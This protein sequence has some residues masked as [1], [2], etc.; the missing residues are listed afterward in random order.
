MPPCGRSRDGQLLTADGVEDGSAVCRSRCAAGASAGAAH[1][2]QF[3]GAHRRLDVGRS[4][5]A[6]LPVQP[7]GTDHRAVRAGRRQALDHEVTGGTSIVETIDGTP[8]AY[9]VAERLIDHGYRGC[10]VLALGTNDTADV[11]ARS[12]VGRIQR[13]KEMMA[14]TGNQPVLWIEV[15]SL[16]SGGPYAE[17]NMRLWNRALPQELPALSGP[18]A[19]T[20]GLRWCAIAGSSTTAFTTR[21]TGTRS[22]PG[23]LP[24]PSRWPSP[25]RSGSWLAHA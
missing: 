12:N 20:T 10:W 24:T 19:S 17:Q 21:R 25:P 7:G 4:D 22:A 3:R 11:Y 2:V 14:L 9:Q 5:L 6:R 13:I 23:S 18:R 15:Q 8:N 1:L 16:V